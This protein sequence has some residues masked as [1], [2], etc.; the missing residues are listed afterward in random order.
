MSDSAEGVDLVLHIG[1]TKTGSTS[2]QHFL[3]EHREALAA[4]GWLYPRT[5]GKSRHLR[6]GFFVKSDDELSRTGA[7]V[8]GDYPPPDVFR[9][10]FPRRLAAE[11]SESGLEHAI[12]S[13]EFLWQ[14]VRLSSVRELIAPIARRTRVVVYL[15][16]Q[17]DHLVSSYQQSVR[18]GNTQRIDVFAASRARA[19]SYDYAAR[20]AAWQREVGPDELVVRRFGSAHFVDGSL[21]QD[22]LSAAGVDVVAEELGT[23]ARRNES[24]D[25]D[26]VEFVRIYN[27]HRIENEGLTPARVR[28]GR[29]SQLL[30]AMPDQGPTLTVPPSVLDDVMARVAESNRAVARDHLGLVGDLFEGPRSDRNTTTVQRLDPARVDAYLHVL[31]IPEEQHAA[32]RAIAEREAALGSLQP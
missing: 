31:D 25:A 21:Y 5:P 17:D 8:T 30:A 1:M 4:R 19:A 29:V 3:R 6:L 15:R 11:V 2:I 18:G 32:I 12:L 24:L 26:A 14:A 9:R 7:W 13:E 23:P 16:R 10:R 27:L 22:F 20:L 28:N